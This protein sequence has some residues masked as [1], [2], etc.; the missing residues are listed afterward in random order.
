MSASV[1]RCVEHVKIMSKRCLEN[2]W[3]DTLGPHGRPLGAH[4]SP[5][6]MAPQGVQRGSGGYAAACGGIGR[7]ILNTI[8]ASSKPRASHGAQGKKKHVIQMW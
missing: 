1:F 3:G 8:S 6:A 5:G 4:G 7:G 2:I